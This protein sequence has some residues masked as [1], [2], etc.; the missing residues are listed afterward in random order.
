[1]FFFSGRVPIAETIAWTATQASIFPAR[2][3]KGRDYANSQAPQS[4]SLFPA[5]KEKK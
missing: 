2:K 1:M 5:K 3:K 4:N